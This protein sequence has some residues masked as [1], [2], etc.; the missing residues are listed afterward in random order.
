RPLDGLPR[1]IIVILNTNRRED[2]LA[3][4]ASLAASTYPAQEIVVVD[5]ASTDGSLAAIGSAYP[6]VHILSLVENRGYA[7]NNNAGIAWAIEHGSDWVLIL[8][9]DTVLAPDCVAQ[10]VEAGESDPRIGMV[11]PTDYHFD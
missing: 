9:E 11:G 1:V 5:N 4:L 6:A 2:T 10:L 7:G 3:C 8:N